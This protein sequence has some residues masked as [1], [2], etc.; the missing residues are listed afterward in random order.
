MR[1]KGRLV[2]GRVVMG[3]VL[4]MSGRDL[5]VRE[6]RETGE[7][8][9]DGNDDSDGH[10]GRVVRIP[11]QPDREVEGAIRDNP[12]IG[13]AQLRNTIMRKCRVD[14]NKSKIKRAKREAIDAIKGVDVVQYNMLWDYCETVRVNNPGSKIILRRAEGSDVFEKLYY[15]LHAM[16][17]G[18][19]EGCRPVIV[20]DGCFLKTVF[21][22]QMLAAVGRD[23][24][25]NMWPIA[26]AIVP[27]ENRENWCWFIREMLDD[28]GGL[29]TNLWSFI[30]DRQKGLIEALKELVPDAAAITDRRDPVEEYIADCY[31]KDMYL[32]CYSHMVHVVPGQ[33]EWV[34]T[35]C[36]PSMPPKI[37][38]KRGRPTKAIRKGTDELQGSI[39][40]RK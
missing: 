13:I 35:G 11:T 33:N 15:S 29:G 3:I 36:D 9:D 12:N 20:L 24:N 28:I 27:V 19:V 17:Q 30:P 10:S 39:S 2:R 31:K 21:G 25:D 32:K 1:E 38:K 4:N 6:K 18:F 16:K 26:L 14:V 40:T 37:K 23:A 5:S 8:Q 7:G 34:Q 22:G